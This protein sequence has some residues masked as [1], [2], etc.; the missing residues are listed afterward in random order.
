MGIRTYISGIP[1]K[2]YRTNK[3]DSREIEKVRMSI[4]TEEVLNGTS[5]DAYFFYSLSSPLTGRELNSGVSR[6][7][8]DTVVRWWRDNVRYVSRE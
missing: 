2:S 4:I 7:D 1:A 6:E 3:K 5:D 8:I